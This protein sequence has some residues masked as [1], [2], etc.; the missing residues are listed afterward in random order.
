[1]VIFFSYIDKWHIMCT[2]DRGAY[3]AFVYNLHLDFGENFWKKVFR[4]YKP[5]L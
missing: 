4:M 2:V 3:P 5:H 1:M